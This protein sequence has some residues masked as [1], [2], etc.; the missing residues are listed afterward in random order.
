MRRVGLLLALC[1]VLQAATAV[2][3]GTIL[4]V[5]NS[6]NKRL[7][8]LVPGEPY[9]V[10]G[11]PQGVYLEHYGVVFT[12][13]VNLVEGPNLSPFRQDIKPT[14][15]AALR[16]RKLDRLPHLRDAMRE[17]LVDS[18]AML[19]TVPANE[20]IVLAISLPRYHWENV[21]GIPGQIV[22]QG[23]RSALVQL[24]VNPSNSEQAI[25]AAIHTREN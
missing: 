17:M 2:S 23:T 18:A 22:M 4:A 21:T 14:E 8:R 16:Q 19:D 6:F 3:R 15:V 25:A 10:L 24:Q 7:E 13:S 20:Q 5:E 11:Q 12:A 9:L 1:A